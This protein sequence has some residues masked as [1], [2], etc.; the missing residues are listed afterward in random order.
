MFKLCV[1]KFVCVEVSS[2]AR[3]IRCESDLTELDLMSGAIDISKRN[4]GLAPFVI[5]SFRNWI[6]CCLYVCFIRWLAGRLLGW[7]V[8]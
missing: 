7:S 8:G 4:I 1:L 6:V 2:F 5:R 3:I